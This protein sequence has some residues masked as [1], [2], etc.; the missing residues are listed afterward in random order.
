LKHDEKRTKKVRKKVI[1]TKNGEG[2]AGSRNKNQ[3][4]GLCDIYLE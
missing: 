1:W 4:I 2:V 3:P